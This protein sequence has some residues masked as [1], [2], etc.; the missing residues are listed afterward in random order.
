[1]GFHIDQTALLK[2]CRVYT[3]VLPSLGW[4]CGQVMRTLPVLWELTVGKGCLGEGDKLV[5]IQGDFLESV[6]SS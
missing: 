2:L 1:M 4:A 3:R 6:V 5:G